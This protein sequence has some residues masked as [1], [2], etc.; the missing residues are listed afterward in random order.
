MLRALRVRSFAIIDE[1][2]LH[3][4]PGLTVITGETG[5]GKS[6]LIDALGLALGDRASESDIRAGAKEAVVEALFDALDEPLHAR[7]DAEGL[8]EEDGSLLVRR[9]LTRDGRSRAYVN[10]SLVPIG[11]VRDLTRSLVD[12]SVQAE[13]HALLDSTSHVAILDRFV[14]RPDLIEAYAAALAKLRAA[15]AARDAL[16]EELVRRREQEDWLAFVAREVADAAPEVGEDD[17]LKARVATLRAAEKIRRAAWEAAGALGGESGARECA[18]RAIARL[19]DIAALDPVAEAAIERAEALRIEAEDLARELERLASRSHVDDAALDRAGDRL[20][21]LRRLCRKYGG[22]IEA[23]IAKGEEARVA[24]DT[25]RNAEVERDRLDTVHDAAL[26]AALGCGVALSSVR[27]EAAARLS[28]DVDASLAA[29]GM[30]RAAFRCVV[31]R[32]AT[33]RCTETG[34]DDVEFRVRTNVGE[35]EDALRRIASGGELSRILL[36]LK[37][38]LSRAD[39]SATSVYDEVDAGLSGATGVVLAAFLKDIAAARQ[40]LCITHLPQVAAAGDIHLHVVK[41][42]REG[43]TISKVRVLDGDERRAEIGRMLGASSE[44]DAAARDHAETLLRRF[45]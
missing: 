4:D 12:L 29:L 2:E 17:R 37:R 14:A 30:E 20:E 45:A 23:V 19:R 7:L 35:P 44:A 16:E 39:P 42:E 38:C 43:R 31:I 22:T 26:Q 25:L 10:G 5:A 6:I 21:V 33:P 1:I 28:S 36:A 41:Q 27:E 32:P 8:G 34:L 13:H 40:V 15:E 24:L 9:V 3:F 18:S 11:T